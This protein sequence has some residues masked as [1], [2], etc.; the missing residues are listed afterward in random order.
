MDIALLL[1]IPAVKKI[2]DLYR[3]LAEGSVQWHAALLTVGSWVLGTGVVALVGASSL[4]PDL[5]LS[6]LALP[7]LVLWGVALGSTAGVI[8]DFVPAANNLIE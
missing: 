4:G 3:F 6:G 7:D 8:H 5:G 2:I 1:A